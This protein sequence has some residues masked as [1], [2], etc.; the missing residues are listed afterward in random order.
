MTIDE[1]IAW[2]GS[3]QYWFQKQEDAAL[4]AEV[5][6]SLRRL[7]NLEAAHAKLKKQLE[8]IEKEADQSF[9]I[10]QEFIEAYHLFCRSYIG[11]GAKI[12]GAQGKAMKAII[13]YLTQVS[14]TKDA[15]GALS[16]WKYILA[17]WSELTKFI[18][19]QTSLVQINKNITEILTQLRRG[20]DKQAAKQRDNQG[21]KDRII[22]RRTT[23]DT[24]PDDSQP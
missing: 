10:Y 6:E 8:D 13:T 17:N 20:K 11:V 22:Q 15:G 18:Q 5:K 19:N 24:G 12:D 7:K 16:A 4:L 3:I 23:G 9:T 14:K 1:Q 2:I 21:V